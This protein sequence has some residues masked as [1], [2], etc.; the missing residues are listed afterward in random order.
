MA[1]R[2]GI[3][4]VGAIGGM[5]GGMLTRGGHDVT[6]IDQWLENVDK[7]KREVIKV[8]IRDVCD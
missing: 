7:M 5:V 1:T 4:G 6:L 2:I 8:N 3:I